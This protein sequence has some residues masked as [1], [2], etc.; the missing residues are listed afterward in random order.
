[1][2]KVENT[3]P[4]F[5][6][7]SIQSE[8]VGPETHA[9]EKVVHNFR[10]MTDTV[11]GD[12][13]EWSDRLFAVHEFMS[14]P[15]GIPIGP[16][17][18]PT[19]GSF[20][21]NKILREAQFV[22]CS[23]ERYWGFKYDSIDVR[24]TVSDPKGLVGGLH[25]GWY[26]YQDYYD[27]DVAET[28]TVVMSKDLLRQGWY[29]G[30]YTHMLGFGTSADVSFTIPWSYKFPV[31]SYRAMDRTD[32]STPDKR[33]IWG[34]PF[35]WW[36]LLPNSAFVTTVHKPAVLMMFL[37]FNGFKWYGPTVYETPEAQPAVFRQ[38][39]AAVVA[40]VATLIASEVGP[41]LVAEEVIGGYVAKESIDEIGEMGT[42]DLPQSVQQAYFGDTTSVDFPNTTPIFFRP[43][44]NGSHPIPK[45]HEI[46]SRP[47]YITEFTTEE[48]DW[49][50]FSN[51]PVSFGVYSGLTDAVYN[52]ATYFRWFGMLARY[53]RGNI[54][55][56][57]L[58][59]GHPMVQVQLETEIRY[60][61]LADLAQPTSDIT[62]HVTT[63]SSTRHTIVPMPFLTMNDYMP[64]FDNFPSN[65]TDFGA[66][67]TILTVRAKVV[68]T[69]LNIDPVIPIYVYMSAGADFKYYQPLPP[70]MYHPEF[71]PVPANRNS[72]RGR[73]QIKVARSE[74]LRKERAK[75]IKSPIVVSLDEKDKDPVQAAVF[76][77]VYLQLEEDH[78]KA[79]SR[80]MVTEDPGTMVYLEDIVDYCK[81]W[82]RAVPFFH[83]DS[84]TDEPEPDALPGFSAP[85]WYPP[86]DR[87]E[88]LD[89]NNSW[90]FTNDYVSYFGSM[91]MYFKGEMGFK[92]SMNGDA[93]I[94]E[95]NVYLYVSLGDC[96]DGLRQQTH[97]PFDYDADQVP[98]ESNFGSGTV[99][100]PASKQP[101]I[102]CTIPYRGSNAWSYTNYNAYLQ[103]Q[104]AT[105]FLF[106]NAEVHHNIVLYND[107]EL[108]LAD[109]MFRKVGSDFCLA[110]ETLLPPPTMW[111]ARGFDWS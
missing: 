3:S 14:Q 24:F 50:W 66:Y 38:M 84:T 26:P 53:W 93:A 61:Y 64:V 98:P 102:E 1:M 99:I 39:E 92:I 63:F 82:S 37:K 51:D 20:V 109:A 32:E 71:D 33:L 47:Q 87:S 12:R 28:M 36:D 5:K 96:D 31:M 70:G 59:L 111:I 81:I 10:N 6:T 60:P 100:T 46:L 43:T 78:D 2:N 72:V 40:E 7:E 105:E 15:L 103:P 30:P 35:L 52:K 80:E 23:G 21:I 44:N 97:V 90:Y 62:R 16:T 58:V 75:K 86:I 77:Q 110:I 27:K 94:R 4:K 79:Y 17:V 57:I 85:W 101:I 48:T 88:D 68:S 42:Y 29:N 108:S 13:L 56:H 25:V 8:W 65:N 91:F 9:K 54:N 74:R 73:Q 19:F 67:T 104:I 106:K 18:S 89:V 83:Y 41:E 55:A 22:K 49:K 11:K 95:Q 45:V 69:M 34:A 76:R 107:D